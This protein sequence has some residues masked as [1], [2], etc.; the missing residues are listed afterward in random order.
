MTDPD[1]PPMFRYIGPGGVEIASG[2]LSL[3]NESL[4]AH[5]SAEASI[6]ATALALGRVA[7][8][9]RRLD[10]VLERER[11]AKARE[12]AAQAIIDAAARKFVDGVFELKHRMDRYEQRAELAKADADLQAVGAADDQLQAPIM[13]SAP[14]DMKESEERELPEAEEA[15]GKS[16]DQYS[17]IPRRGVR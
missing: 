5:E 1:R 7:E 11:A 13:A 2:P 14:E 9:D 8:A 17:T 15:I 4:R 12:D 6:K 3:L 10:S 16:D